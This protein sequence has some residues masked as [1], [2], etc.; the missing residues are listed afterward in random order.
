MKLLLFENLRPLQ[1]ESQQRNPW[2]LSLEEE[3]E[4]PSVLLELPSFAGDGADEVVETTASVSCS[5]F[6][7]SR[8]IVRLSWSS[9]AELA[10]VS[11]YDDVRFCQGLDSI[12]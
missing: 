12:L 1:Q 2:S 4:E 7:L 5:N 3:E 9:R 10:T 11:A 8:V 6:R